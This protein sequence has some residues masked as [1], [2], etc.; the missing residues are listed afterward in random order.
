MEEKEQ[1]GFRYKFVNVFWY[2]Y[3]KLAIAA[4]IAIAV[5]I[6]LSIDA[7]NKE[8]YDLNAVVAVDRRPSEE[9]IAAL[10]RLLEDAVGD[11]SG[12]GQ[13]IINLQRVDLSDGSEQERLLLY[14]TLPEYTLFILND[15][16]SLLYG[17]KEDTF[18]PLADY[19]IEAS[20]E[21]EYRA[22]IG[23]RAPLQSIGTDSYL[24]LSDW[25]VD[26][27]GSREMTEAAV[28]AIKAILESPIVQKDGE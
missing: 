24:C 3:G 1:K 21:A 15:R 2:H 26:G 10:T 20:A 28:R 27:K 23:D 19:G 25:T 22:F 6:W 5:V 16:A 12:D 17:S 18:Q 13:C 4:V 11:V 9:D 14:Q 7:F 8:E